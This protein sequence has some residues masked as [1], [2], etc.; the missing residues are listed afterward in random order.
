MALGFPN[1]SRSYDADRHR[2]R[3]WGYDSSME[4][5]FFIEEAALFA[6]YPRTQN[7]EDGILSAF[8]TARDRIMEVAARVYSA[9][10]GRQPAYALA[11]SDF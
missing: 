6:L 3:F 11:A 5:S 4:I 8:D 9:S 1:P 2:V 7:A 10:R